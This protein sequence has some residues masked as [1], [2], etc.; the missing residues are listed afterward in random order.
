V[1][2]M[3]AMSMV[4]VLVA[5]ALVL[6]FGIARLDRTQN[7][8]V[9][10]SAVAAGMRGLDMGDARTHSF[11]GVCQALNFLKANKPALSSLSWAPCG[12]PAKLATICKWDNPL[13]HAS[14]SGSANGVTVEIRSPYDLTS[15]T[16][17]GWEEEALATLA[18]D[19]L[20]AQDACNHVAVIVRQTRQPGLGSLATDS[21]MTTAVRSVGRVAETTLDDQPVALLLLERMDCSAVVV[22]GGN[23]FVRVLASGNVPGLIHSDSTGELCTGNSHILTGD[24]ANGIIARSGANAP[25]IIRVRAI[26]TT[27]TA[28]A[29][30]S[31][32]NTVAEGGV[33][34]PGP[35]VGRSPVDARY[36]AA[37][38]GAISDYETQAATAGAG[39]T[40]RNC[41]AAKAQLESVTGKLW[42]N[43]GTNTFNTSGVTL[44]ASTVFF[45]AKSVSAPDLAMPN[46]TQVYVRGDT[47]TNG[48]GISVSG[49]SFS[50][51]SG[52]SNTSCPDTVTTPTMTR[53]RL[54]IGAGS[55]SSN[56]S[57][58]VKLCGTTLVLR[59]GVTG[60][61]VPTVPGTGP[62]DTVTCNG[63]LDM[64]GATDWTAPNKVAGQ[65][66]PADWLDFE[67]MAVWVE[68]RGSHDIGG[69]AAMRMS[70]VFFLPNGEFKVHGGANQDVKN[71]Q[72][73]ARRFRADGGSLLELQPNPYDVIGVPALTG[74][75]LVR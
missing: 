3:V 60:G 53:A 49:S 36:I 52:S 51:G 25:G 41:N 62:S 13:T 50:M 66:T 58:N 34:G 57:S 61:C 5:A 75:E 33:V 27:A 21:D 69:G 74:F 59:G 12:D 17:T 64:N 9:A 65:A 45:D 31:A 16:S 15:A 30:D 63:R 6:D 20:T 39:W 35:L 48:T 2:V 44:S 18:A 47:S 32:T 71:S 8:S 26:G 24:H 68:A 55:F 10:D 54:V 11:N 29:Y 73:I 23:S 56:P 14:F 67:D 7:K 1:T 46:A 43:C 37:A 42:I 70:G 28:H 40:T 22:N 72:Y 38:R 4:A 19:R